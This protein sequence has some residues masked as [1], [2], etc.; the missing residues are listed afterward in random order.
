MLI[1]KFMISLLVAIQLTATEASTHTSAS[2]STQIQVE[3]AFLKTVK[4]TTVSARVPG[5][6][7]TLDIEEGKAIEQ[8][9][10]LGRLL[11]SSIRLQIIRA[12][13]AVEKARLQTENDIDRR[14]AEKRSAVAINELER[15][16]SSNSKIPNTYPA[17][18]IDRLQLVADS[19]ILEI[20]RAQYERDIH[21]QELR[22]AEV[23]LDQ[24]RDLLEKH[25]IIAPVD[26]VVIAV[27]KSR[28]EWTEPGSSLFQ[29]LQTKTL[30]IEGFVNSAQAGV[31]LQGK[32]AT[33]SIDLEGEKHSV[34]GTVTF[35]SPETN[36]VNGQVRVFL[37][38]ENPD[39]QFRSGVR[40]D[41]VIDLQKQ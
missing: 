11:D 34:P 12:E 5:I 1:A 24:A 23:E 10:E 7:D 30:R 20:E 15:A 9:Q 27:D 16:V 14:L 3:N 26:G 18:E 36:P 21:A 19:T 2:E 31:G 40:V 4:S 25:R 28:G 22:A 41:A 35:V 8:G 39:N 37:E 29:I 13:V 38:I 6:I 17:K 32:S 33:I